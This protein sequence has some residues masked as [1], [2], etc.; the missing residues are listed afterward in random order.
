M[1]GGAGILF[2]DLP[3]DISHIWRLTMMFRRTQSIVGIGATRLCRDVFPVSS[4]STRGMAMMSKQ[5]KSQDKSLGSSATSPVLR[6]EG[7]RF[8]SMRVVYTNVE[9][10]AAEWKIMTRSEALKFAKS[11][12]LDLIL[13]EFLN[14]VSRLSQ[15]ILLNELLICNVSVNG[16]ADPPVCKVEDFV[17]KVQEIKTKE[18]EMKVSKKARSLKEMFMTGGIEKRDFLTKMKKVNEF[19]TTGHPVKVTVVPKRFLKN[20]RFKNGVRRDRMHGEYRSIHICM[21]NMCLFI[22]VVQLRL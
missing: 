17:K 10:G 3:V 12:D 20:D 2:S 1:V 19:L 21:K 11:L 6:N 16:K 13:G 15:P 18:K 8:P 22:Y 9:T 7:I 14:S 4:L 5:Y